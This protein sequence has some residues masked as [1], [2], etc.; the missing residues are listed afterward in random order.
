MRTLVAAGLELAT[1]VVGPTRLVG[2]GLV[3]Q[4]GRDAHWKCATCMASG[5]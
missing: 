4:I 5:T 1:G 2:V 3:A